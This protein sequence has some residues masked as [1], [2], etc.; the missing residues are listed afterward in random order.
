MRLPER[1]RWL[2]RPGVLNYLIPSTGNSGG[3]IIDQDGNTSQRY[4]SI[5]GPPTLTSSSHSRTKSR[6]RKATTT[7]SS[8]SSPA[9]TGPPALIL[10]W[11]SGGGD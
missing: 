5:P 8:S 3:L 2:L 6:P 4:W 9:P 1:T 7:P 11:P 10:H